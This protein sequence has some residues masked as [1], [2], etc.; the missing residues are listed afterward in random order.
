M[1]ASTLHLPEGVPG[2]SASPYICLSDFVQKWPSGAAGSQHKARFILVITNGVDPYNGSTSVMNQ[3]SPYVDAAIAD[4]QRAGV[5]VYAIYF[6]DA[7]L[8]NATN[9]A[10]NS[11]QDYLQQLTQGTGGVNFWEGVGN[12]QSTAPF[13]KMFQGAIAETYIATF[14]APAGKDPRD[15]VRVKFT[16]ARVKL[17]AADKVRPGNQE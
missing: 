15:L 3:G 7:G 14:N 9:M 13:L 16:A 5:A 10:D 4:A 12:P 11:G 1:A 6:A 17:H 8:A 2:M